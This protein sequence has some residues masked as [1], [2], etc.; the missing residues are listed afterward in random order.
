MAA[1]K[2]SSPK[3]H[4]WIDLLRAPCD[5]PTGHNRKSWRRDDRIP[6]TIK[7]E[8]ER[9]SRK[10]LDAG[11]APNHRSVGSAHCLGPATIIRT[12][13]S[14]GTTLAGVAHKAPSKWSSQGRSPTFLALNI[15]CHLFPNHPQLYTDHAGF[16]LSQEQCWTFAAPQGMNA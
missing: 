12:R 14:I 7:S 5:L 13:R 16:W 3:G 8:K 2:F 11:L 1:Y 10:R 6:A 9:A 15:S 4:H